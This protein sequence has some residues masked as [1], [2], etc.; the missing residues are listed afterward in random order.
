MCCE[1]RLLLS[2]VVFRMRFVD[3]ARRVSGF[4]GARVISRLECMGVKV[5]DVLRLVSRNIVVC[6]VGNQVM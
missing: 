3:G 5:R 2:R 6:K 1:E 4:R